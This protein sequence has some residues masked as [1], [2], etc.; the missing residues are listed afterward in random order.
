MAEGDA[1]VLN[2]SLEQANAELRGHEVG[3]LQSLAAIEC[4]VNLDVMST[5]VPH[6]LGKRANCLE[7]L[8]TTLHINEPDLLDRKTVVTLD[9]AIHEL[10]GVAAAAADG[11]N[12]ESV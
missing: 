2:T 6:A 10:R 1:L 4:E 3:V 11:A 12:L 8:A 7:L 9:E 5:L